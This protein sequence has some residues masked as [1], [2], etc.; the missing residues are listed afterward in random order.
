MKKFEDMKYDETT[1]LIAFV[2]TIAMMLA[3]FLGLICLS[4]V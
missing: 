3:G 4:Q 1:G 2:L